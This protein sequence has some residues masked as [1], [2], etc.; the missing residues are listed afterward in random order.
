MKGSISRRRMLTVLGTTA[1]AAGLGG[2]PD[3]PRAAGAEAPPT[4]APVLIPGV[5]R[6]DI[7]P[8]T[9]SPAPCGL[10]SE[11]A[12][13]AANQRPL[14]QCFTFGG[15]RSMPLRAGFRGRTPATTGPARRSRYSARPRTGSA[16]AE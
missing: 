5:T 6:P 9:W 16:P 3:V 11:Q 10:T 8:E 14:D 7:V 12:A 4:E 15:T 1:G 13:A 2:L